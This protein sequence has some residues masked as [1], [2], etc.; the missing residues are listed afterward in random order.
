MLTKQVHSVFVIEPDE[1]GVGD[2]LAIHLQHQLEHRRALHSTR[3]G[4]V[5]K[6]T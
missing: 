4:P 2:L 3:G 1:P 5:I 6:K